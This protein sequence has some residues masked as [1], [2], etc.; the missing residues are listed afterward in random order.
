MK[1]YLM[2]GIFI[3]IICSIGISYIINS[4]NKLSKTLDNK[5]K[6]KLISTYN[7]P[8]VPES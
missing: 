8:I 5:E 1:K 4:P 2:I 7:N 3:M 6:T